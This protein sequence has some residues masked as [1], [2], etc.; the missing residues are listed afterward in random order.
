MT[1]MMPCGDCNQS[2]FSDGVIRPIAGTL[3]DG[4]QSCN[5]CGGRGWRNIT[6]CGEDGCGECDV[7]EYLDFLD[8]VDA[9]APPGNHITRIPEIEA[10]LKERYGS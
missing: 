10:L 2:G 3:P 6:D 5:T 7:C 9:V 8:Y 4:V 1:K